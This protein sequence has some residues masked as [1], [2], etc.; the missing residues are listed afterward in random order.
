MCIILDLFLNICI[1]QKL[2]KM[3]NSAPE[4]ERVECRMR[5]FINPFSAWTVCRRQIRTYKDGPRTERIKIF[6]TAVNPY[7]TYSNVSERAITKSFIV[8]SNW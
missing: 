2:N 3:L 4:T 6:I 5:H 1:G 7:H 8:I